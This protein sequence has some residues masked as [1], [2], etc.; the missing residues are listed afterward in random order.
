[1]PPFKYP[2]IK[3]TFPSPWKLCR[4]SSSTIHWHYCEFRGEGESSGRIIQFIFEYNNNKKLCQWN[5]L[6]IEIRVLGKFWL[7]INWLSDVG[8]RL[9]LPLRP[10]PPPQPVLHGPSRHS[11]SC[12][13]ITREN[14][15]HTVLLIFL[16]LWLVGSWMAEDD[17]WRLMRRDYWI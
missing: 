9:P 5:V 17:G 8:R 3:F 2:T 16:G 7:T 6:Q 13:S 10:P 15:Q 1:M 4:D 11:C 14:H 12:W